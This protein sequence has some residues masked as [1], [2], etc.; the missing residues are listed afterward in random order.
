MVIFDVVVHSPMIY[1]P[2]YYTLKEFVGGSSWSPTDWVKDG[3]RKYYMNARQ[4][5]SAMAVVTIPS[6]MVQV[7]MPLHT[8]MIFRHFISFFWTSYVSFSRGA[9]DDDAKDDAAMEEQERALG[10][11][12]TPR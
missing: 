12:V 8:R 5:L 3:L 11:S 1:F 6:D 10:L 9:L 7:M 2:S 4:D